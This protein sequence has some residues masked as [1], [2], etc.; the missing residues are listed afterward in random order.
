[1]TKPL[2]SAVIRAKDRAHTIAAA[3]QSVQ[4]QT[5]PGEVIV[6]DSGSTDGTVEIAESLGATVIRI[7]PE[8]FTYGRAINIGVRASSADAV[9]I[10]SAHCVLPN[11][12][13]IEQALGFFEDPTVAALN[14]FD[15]PRRANPTSRLSPGRS[16]ELGLATDIVRQSEAW[17]SFTG[18]SNH[19][20]MVRRDVALAEPFDEMLEACEDKEWANRVVARGGS[21]VYV[22]G[23][24]VSGSH[25]RREGAR[26]LYRR[27]FRESRAMSRLAGS[28][29][30]TSGRYARHALRM[31]GARRGFSRLAPLRP[32]NVVESWGRLNGARQGRTPE[33]ADLT[34]V[35]SLVSTL[36]S[37]ADFRG[38]AVDI[39]GFPLHDNCGDNAIW[40]GQNDV[41]RRLGVDPRRIRRMSNVLSEFEPRS[42]A[43]IALVR[44][45]GYFGDLWVHE[46]QA[47]L[48]ACRLYAGGTLVFMPQSIAKISPAT[49][50]EAQRAIAAHGDVHLMFRDHRSLAIAEDNFPG[51]RTYLCT[52][53]AQALSRID[54]EKVGGAPDRDL[55]PKR[56]LARSDAEGDGSLVAAAKERGHMVLDFVGTRSHAF[57][58]LLRWGHEFARVRLPRRVARQILCEILPRT[59]V[60]DLHARLEVRRALRLIRG[61]ELLVT[62]RLHAAI[63]ASSLGIE[64]VA[65]DTGYGKLRTYFDAWPNSRVTFAENVDDALDRLHG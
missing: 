53:S 33:L 40:L 63:L 5:I 59:P 36:S 41:L 54:L 31:F 48:D 13:W 64:V 35:D 30:W 23:M 51:A 38:E 1:M 45:G 16:M 10:L 55:P 62:D 57:N 32:A 20:S 56:V 7:A 27:A 29:I 3:I 25:R 22:P 24:S 2:F 43:Q 21:V 8:S 17:F 12:A 49:I 19:G 60:Y 52:D 50:A 9:L 6:V 18:F 15:P 26:L 11:A 61:A 44:G 34:A 58:R 37:I 39:L 4:A 28:P 47:F 14:G 42:R 46:F 65:V